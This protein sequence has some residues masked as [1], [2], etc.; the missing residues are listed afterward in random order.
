MTVLVTGGAGYVG[1]TLVDLLSQ[2]GKHVKSIDNYTRGKYEW[3]QELDARENVSFQEGD[4][5]NPQDV[6][7]AMD[8]VD[9][10][11]HLAALP[12]LALCSQHPQE[13]INTNIYGT[14]NLLTSA[15]D[16]DVTRFIFAS[17]A[18]AYGLP[19]EFPIKET[20][21]I[22]PINLYGVTKTASE[23]LVR[24]KNNVN[25]LSTVILRFA[26]IYGVGVYTYWE[27]VIP[28]FVR[29]GLEGKPLPVY[30]SGE[31]TR[32]FIHVNDIARG[33]KECLEH[34]TTEIAGEA[35]NLGSGKATSINQVATLVKQLLR[36]RVNKKVKIVHTE[37]REGEPYNPNFRFSIRKIKTKLGFTPQEK[38]KEGIIELI[39]E[40]TG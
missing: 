31:Q 6:E 37:K 24:T 11:V 1:S 29:L 34:D 22:Q 18:A 2:Q 27:T 9:S 17:S 23:Y 25:N 35:F 26:N 14:W 30:G 40:R 19:E 12:G 36:Q 8:T 20:E 32:D 16:H 28:K 7:K 3:V 4:I 21:P 15:I 33:I 10:V 13:A 39:R 5:R 38:L